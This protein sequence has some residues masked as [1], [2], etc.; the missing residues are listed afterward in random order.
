MK[1]PLGSRANVSELMELLDVIESTQFSSLPDSWSE[2]SSRVVDYHP[3]QVDE[4]AYFVLYDPW[5]HRKTDQHIDTNR[6]SAT[7][8]I[9][10]DM[11]FGWIH[12]VKMSN[13][14]IAKRLAIIMVTLV[15][16]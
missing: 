4:G 10:D 6:A 8:V 15:V 3:C 12:E 1:V 13:A 16:W 2:R 9:T 11:P 14:H 5:M 7:R